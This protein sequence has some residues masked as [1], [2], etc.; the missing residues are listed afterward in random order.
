MNHTRKSLIGKKLY[1][2]SKMFSFE[3]AKQTVNQIAAKTHPA[4]S[5]TPADTTYCTQITNKITI[6]S[7]SG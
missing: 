2:I 1:E 5:V 6:Y 4:R 3:P 7:V